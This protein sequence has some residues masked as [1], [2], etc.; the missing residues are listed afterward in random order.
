MKTSERNG[1][2]VGAMG[3]NDDDQLLLVTASGKIIRMS[4]DGISKIGRATQGVKVIQTA[5]DD[6]VVSAIRTA[7]AEVTDGDGA[8]ESENKTEQAD[9]AAEE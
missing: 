3:V 2:V 8:D 5:A 6:Q 9:A 1:H 7:E 4:V